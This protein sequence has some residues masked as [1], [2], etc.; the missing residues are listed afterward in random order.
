MA[1]KRE[2]ENLHLGYEP[3]PSQAEFHR[4]GYRF[5][6]F[7][8]PVGSGKSAALCFEALRMG[9]LNKG[10]TGL[11]AAPTYPMLRD[12][13]LLALV[14][15]LEENRIPYE[16]N[17]AEMVLTLKKPKSRILLRSLD[18]PEKLRGTNLAW[19]GVDEL[20]YTTEDAWTRLVAR[21]RD[22]KAERLC[23]FAVWTPKGHDWVYRR[24]LSGK[25]PSYVTT[26]AKPMENKHIT[27][28]I[29]DFYEK[30][31]ESYD[32]KF[33]RQEVLGEYLNI[34]E[35]RVYYAFDSG[36]NVE[37]VN[38]D[39]DL[40]LIW[41]L[42]FNFDPLCSVVAQW[43]HGRFVVLDELVL[44]R[45]TTYEA[46][47]EFHAKYGDHPED[48][49]V[50]GDSSANQHRTAGGSDVDAFR[51]FRNEKRWT[52]MKLEFAKS[53][54]A[55]RDRIAAVNLSMADANG[56]VGMVIDPQCRQLIRDLESVQYEAE[57]SGIEKTKDASLTHMSDAL[58]Y[59]VWQRNQPKRAC[60]LQQ[61]RLT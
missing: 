3:L 60:G 24:F 44:R 28:A 2:K 59:M 51:R 22:P 8:G 6:G 47:E 31:K 38:V 15:K 30:L 26:I 5:K 34:N 57:G 12:A 58:G 48:V 61:K 16:L 1:N 11:L 36:R 19:F 43:Q 40:P 50:M 29:G 56:R 27:G 55:V 37:P 10:R 9:Y 14:E 42:D 13:T 35:S 20:T 54:P 18:D 49:V 32:E 46:C 39:R 25:Y 33:Y 23:G 7:S 4:Y 52:R 21:L 17:K 53:N 41:S 45:K